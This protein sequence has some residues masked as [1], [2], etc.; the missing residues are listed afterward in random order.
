MPSVIGDRIAPLTDRRRSADSVPDGTAG[1]FRL[2]GPAS[3]PVD[4]PAGLGELGLARFALHPTPAR[5]ESAR[6]AYGSTVL[7]PVY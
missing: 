3:A 6:T 1:R 2:L 7:S 5:K 4:R